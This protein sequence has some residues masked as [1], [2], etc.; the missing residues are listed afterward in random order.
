LRSDIERG[1]TIGRVFA[2]YHAARLAVDQPADFQMA[3]ASVFLAVDLAAFRC[4]K[5]VS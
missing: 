5:K 3:F 2:D 4:C 1:V